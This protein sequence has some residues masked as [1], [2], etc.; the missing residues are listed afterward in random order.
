MRAS[1][2]AVPMGGSAEP[3][4]LKGSPAHMDQPGVEVHIDQGCAVQV[5]VLTQEQATDLASSLLA[6][7]RVAA[8]VQS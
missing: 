6:A 8:A 2:L 1:Y 3:V 4:Q 7:A 5:M